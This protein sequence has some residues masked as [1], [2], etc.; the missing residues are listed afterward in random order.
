MEIIPNSYIARVVLA[1]LYEEKLNQAA[2]EFCKT[3]PYLREEREFVKRGF[4]PTTC[5]SL[6]LTTLFRD[7][8]EMQQ[9]VDVFVQKHGV[10]LDIQQDLSLVKKVEMVLALLK[11][12][13]KNRRSV[14]DGLMAKKDSRKS[15][16]VCK[17]KRSVPS[18]HPS[19]SSSTP[20]V[21]EPKQKRI[22]TN[23]P[24]CIVL[25]DSGRNLSNL[26]HISPIG[27]A[28]DS[29]QESC[30]DDDGDEG[31]E[32]GEEEDDVLDVRKFPSI[33]LFSRT[34]LENENYSEK[35]ADLINKGR[36]TSLCAQ[37]DP[38]EGPSVAMEEHVDELISFIVNNAVK[39]KVFDDI[40]ADISSKAIEEQ[41]GNNEDGT[42]TPPSAD[43]PIKDRL[44]K[45]CRK[46]YNPSSAK[47]SSKKVKVISD[48]PYYG[49]L[50]EGID[51]EKS[52]PA[53]VTVVKVEPTAQ[54]SEKINTQST[55][56]M[57]QPE[58]SS[59]AEQPIATTS[60]TQ[61][62]VIQPDNT[63]KLVD[64][65]QLQF[66]T[67]QT[68]GLSDALG[69]I[70][71][72]SAFIPGT[73]ILENAYFISVPNCYIESNNQ[74]P[75][76]LN[77]Y[78]PPVVE[79]SVSNPSVAVA[80]EPSL[81]KFLI[82]PS[83][84]SRTSIVSSI[85]DTA[86]ATSTISSSC[87]STVSTTAI[88]N[89]CSSF[90]PLLPKPEAKSPPQP[91][92]PVIPKE[93]VE[94]TP[95]NTVTLDVKARS[96]STPSHKAS[97]IRILNFHTPAKQS[98]LAAGISNR[99]ATPGSAPPAVDVRSRCAP[100][101]VERMESIPETVNK[102]NK[103]DPTKSPDKSIDLNKSSSGGPA[104]N[105]NSVSNTPRVAKD[106]RTCVRVLSRSASK[107]AVMEPPKPMV[108]IPSAAVAEVQKKIST[109]P[110]VKIS[111]AEMEEW[112]R[113]RS[114]SKSNFDQHLR[115]ME[116]Q[117]LKTTPCA[118]IRKK[119]KKPSN[120]KAPPANKVPA[121]PEEPESTSAKGCDS[122]ESLDA[123]DTSITDLHGQML[124]DA[125]A[126]AKKPEVEKQPAKTPAKGKTSS[127]DPNTSEEHGS[128]IYVKIATP[129]KK[130]PMKTSPRRRF[131]KGEKSVK[132]RR[133]SN[134]RKKQ[135][136]EKKSVEQQEEEI[137]KEEPMEEEIV[138]EEVTTVKVV[139]K[140]TIVLKNHDA[141]EN[142]ESDT[143]DAIAPKPVSVPEPEPESESKPVSH[144]NPISEP[145]PIQEPEP[146]TPVKTEENSLSQVEETP[147]EVPKPVKDHPKLL[148]KKSSA[149]YVR[150]EQEQSS[151]IAS[152]SSGSHEL[153]S[154]KSHTSI[155][156]SFSTSLFLETP[157]K[158][159][160]GSFPITPR[161]LMPAQIENTPMTRS[162]REGV[163][164]NSS[165]KKSGDIHTPIFPITPGL[166]STPKSTNSVSPHSMGGTGGFSSR[167]TD[168]SSGSSYYKPDESEDLDKNLEAMLHGE[169]KK[170]KA[171]ASGELSVEK[172]LVEEP[173]P[174]LE[175][176]PQLEPNPQEQ[177]DATANVT[178]SSTDSSSS[179][180]SSSDSSGS[181]GSSTEN[182]PIKRPENSP[183]PSPIKPSTQYLNAN[184]ARRQQQAE[185]EAK[186]QR[187]I[188]R[189]KNAKP[190][191]PKKMERKFVAPLGFKSRKVVISRKDLLPKIAPPPV[192]ATSLTPSASSKRKN[193][194]PRKVIVLDRV[195]TMSPKKHSPKRRTLCQPQET[196]RKSPRT[197]LPI[198][199]QD[200]QRILTPRKDQ[201]IEGTYES[202]NLSRLICTPDIPDLDPDKKPVYAFMSPDRGV[203][204]NKPKG[205]PDSNKENQ[206]LEE[207]K[208]SVPNTEEAHTSSEEED[209]PYSDCKFESCYEDTKCKSF[210]RVTFNEKKSIA[211]GEQS[212][213]LQPIK[214]LNIVLEE[215]RRVCLDVQDPI[216]IFEQSPS[217][218]KPPKTAAHPKKKA[219][220]SKPRRNT[221]RIPKKS[222]K[223]MEPPPLPISAVSKL[224]AKINVIPAVRGLGLSPAARRTATQLLV[225]KRRHEREILA[226]SSK[227]LKPEEP[228][229]D[230]PKIKPLSLAPS[231]ENI[232]ASSSRELP[233]SPSP[234][235]PLKLDMKKKQQE[236]KRRTSATESETGNTAVA[237]PKDAKAGA[238]SEKKLEGEFVIDA[239][240]THLHG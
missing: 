27:V 88:N 92:V 219:T 128:K 5:I 46:N 151:A 199:E 154:E 21:G 8:G 10:E 207:P 140:T 156:C 215:G 3:S 6:K 86:A 22:C 31:H 80:P 125:L 77:A 198:T 231:S 142:K 184:D 130:T 20:E 82:F 237:A 222:T 189:M 150:K 238:A 158:A 83:S 38:K 74:V 2:I 129:R 226:A 53:S 187:T 137:Q 47:R 32:G 63:T 81:E 58:V 113:I 4:R 95:Q 203:E 45:T 223:P 216:V 116:E 162:I 101:L 9:K 39:D 120:R 234:K 12:A 149:E 57:I 18:P 153:Q 177:E 56:A 165:M 15:G 171:E 71:S 115:L 218:S 33:D 190:A 14:V 107:E 185:L 30:R 126:S 28:D 233:V 13:H 44:R 180:S 102:P 110:R 220:S 144:A 114:V 122:F 78:A 155:D 136:I 68:G 145:K 98:A 112:R 201:V 195:L 117:R 240:L 89:I 91:T 65:N 19:L 49:G 26:S 138:V 139:E 179:S 221:A 227:K 186:K 87:T 37:P 52:E 235:M 172:I 146:E 202:E 70:P 106:P 160:F 197:T 11:Q 64:I 193:P 181:D 209:D 214:K 36:E 225:A 48:V 213:E 25:N 152:T 131:S 66:P 94:I 93:E 35:I 96:N 174:Q 133:P 211:S 72:T 17:R 50:P 118:P 182:T 134:P 40:L 147:P 164:S 188:A 173:P 76:Y 24:A 196:H 51:V 105:P 127:K 99:V 159:D 148:A 157:L 208:Q 205:T 217:P 192:P 178:V 169:W 75:I 232:A 103:P 67:Q 16:L 34:L 191:Q 121:S 206:S 62:Y 59:T 170:R 108:E 79:P 135:A 43:T 1:Y 212:A 90:V 54:A 176:N 163:Q 109:T 55:I 210:F 124:E 69:S 194:T 41:T 168:Y 84:S 228:P 175:A 224:K 104:P 230:K 60:T 167:R 166:I 236:Q 111:D 29:T 141:E 61:F 183:T 239:V 85:T 204:P 23:P 73:G 200:V 97:H 123:A 229:A 119:R 100:S 143:T 42:T 132:R 161:F 7:Y